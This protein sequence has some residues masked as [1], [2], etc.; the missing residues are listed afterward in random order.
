VIGPSVQL[1]AAGQNVRLVQTDA[2]A[3]CKELGTVTGAGMSAYDNERAD[4]A[5]NDLRNSAA[6]LGA[7][8]VRL[9]GLTVEPPNANATGTA[10]ACP[11][12]APAPPA[13]PQ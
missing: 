4:R 2:P 6:A 5:K 13:T 7:N 9:E 1:T 8:Y 10:Y 11:V 3:G 12:V